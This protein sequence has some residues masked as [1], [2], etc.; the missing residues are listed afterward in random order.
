MGANREEVEA[1]EGLDVKSKVESVRTN[2][3]AFC[4][5]PSMFLERLEGELKMEGSM[6]SESTSSSKNVGECR[7]FRGEDRL[8]LSGEERDAWIAVGRTG[9]YIH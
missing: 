9:E 5:V 4:G 1:G 2:L 3:E 6:F 8:A 7:R